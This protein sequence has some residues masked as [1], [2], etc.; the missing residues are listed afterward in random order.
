MSFYWGDEDRNDQEARRLVNRAAIYTDSARCDWCG[1][2]LNGYTSE[3][4]VC[5]SLLCPRHSCVDGKCPEH[6]QP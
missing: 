5:K 4:P 6:T 1:D 2:Q 3:C